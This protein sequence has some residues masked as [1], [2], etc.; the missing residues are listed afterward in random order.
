MKNKLPKIS[1]IINAKN[2]ELFI[3]DCLKSLKWTDEVLV[4]INPDSSDGTKEI[5]KK[6][7]AKILVQ[8]P[9][10]MNYAA[11]HNQGL[12]EGSGDWLLWVDADERVTPALKNEI[13][14]AINSSQFSAYAIPRRNFLLGR[15]LHYGGWYPDYAKRFFHKKSLKNWS[16]SVHEE[17]E[18]EGK[19]G[20][21][22]N[23][24]LHLQPERIEPALQKS[25]KWSDIEAKLL[26]D[27]NHPRIVWWRV[28]RMGLT[29]LTF[30]L[31]K[32][33]GF[34]DGVEGWIE[35]IYQAYHTMIVYLKLWELQRK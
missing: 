8:E 11:W 24:M 28:I 6:Y 13:L 32:M 27:V 29:T 9:R 14:S 31:I 5:A 4:F 33:Q 21:L 20:L 34:R 16:G 19:M 30:R 23:P 12:K 22:T 15:E 1:A 26:F 10:G 35:S 17:P 3:E 7:R 25:V 18:F 2:E